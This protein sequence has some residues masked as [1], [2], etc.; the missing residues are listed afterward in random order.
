M[1][2]ETQY[3]PLD[4]LLAK[5]YNNQMPHIQ[6]AFQLMRQVIVKYTRYL[7]DIDG[8]LYESSHAED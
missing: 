6:A 2:N 4:P 8:D 5:R 7:G 3:N 1:L